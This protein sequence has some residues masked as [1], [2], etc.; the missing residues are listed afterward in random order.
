MNNTDT[1][2]T[3]EIQIAELPVEVRELA[4]KISEEKRS[5]VQTI[6]RQVF[7]GTDEWERQV[8]AITVKDVNDKMS[9]DLAEV[10]RKNAK[11]ARLNAE[12]IF[13]EKREQV[14]RLK[15]EYDL[16]D[17]LWLK[18]KQI[19]QIKL[20]TIEEKAEWKATFVKRF[21][22]EQKELKIQKR[23]NEV[24]KYAEINRLEFENMSDD[25]FESFL[26]GL[27]SNYE[28]KIKAEKE[29]KEMRIA[30]EKADAEEREQQRLENKRLKAE[31]EVKEKQLAEER[32]KAKA[33]IDRI[34]AEN[35]AKLRAEQEAKAKLEAELWQK[36][37]DEIKIEA[38]RKKQEAKMKA[39]AE[40]LARAPLKKQLRLWVASFTIPELGVECPEKALI[41][42]KFI[43]FK[44]W[45]M[46]QVEN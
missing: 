8:D 5:E 45:A 18:A 38:D 41:T 31:A 9:I 34:Q 7:V 14:Q 3:M 15:S 35:I 2:K 33:E 27:K 39:D 26:S 24:L 19:M 40:K 30:K 28:V 1:N 25:S 32:A 21:E 44:K 23:I 46:D 22:A 16:E 13:D 42:D 17:K 12:K 36:K 6:L 10:A 29:A 43:S 20:K 4:V 37:Q 11:Q